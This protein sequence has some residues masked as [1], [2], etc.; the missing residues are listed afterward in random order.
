[1]NPHSYLLR[2]GYLVSLSSSYISAETGLLGKAE[3]GLLGTLHFYHPG[4]VY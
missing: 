2:L 4:L 3:A 1:M